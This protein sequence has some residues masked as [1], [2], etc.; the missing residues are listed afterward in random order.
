MF[1]DVGCEV[2][3][4]D[5]LRIEVSEDDRVV[6]LRWT[7]RSVDREPGKFITPVLTE[8]LKRSDSGRKKIIMDF[9]DLSYMNSSTITPI[10][11]VLDRIKRGM[12]NIMLMYDAEKKWQELSFSA[13][14]I[15]ETSDGRVAV[16]EQ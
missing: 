8:M 9:K 6:M 3:E 10:I 15:F 12:G 2:F 14:R 5:L 4:N 16:K 13:L 1:T 7:G 11:K